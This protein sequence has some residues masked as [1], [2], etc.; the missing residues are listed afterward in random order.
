[1][2]MKGTSFVVGVLPACVAAV[3]IA[4]TVAPAEDKMEEAY[5]RVEIK[6]VLHT[7]VGAIGGESTG[8]VIKAGNVTW[9]LD[10]RSNNELLALA[11]K[12]NE[13][14]V[15]VTGDYTQKKGVEVR[16]R[17]IVKVKTLKEAAAN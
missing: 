17:H 6:G 15:V 10:L 7:G 14:T 12:L 11:E 8:I 2:H 4:A 1:M 9:E 3:F 5:I 16:L 13:K